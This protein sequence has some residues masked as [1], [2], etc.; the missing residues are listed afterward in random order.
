[1]RFQPKPFEVTHMSKLVYEVNIELFPE[2]MP[3][4]YTRFTFKRLSIAES[5]QQGAERMGLNV[6]ILAK[7]IVVNPQNEIVR[8]EEPS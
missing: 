8:E 6:F 7:R 1:M 3:N 5:M 2:S 4:A